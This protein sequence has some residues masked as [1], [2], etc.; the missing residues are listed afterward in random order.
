MKWLLI[1]LMMEKFYIPLFSLVVQ[2]K[3]EITKGP[4]EEWII[5]LKKE[6]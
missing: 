2:S 5:P 3:K 1:A 6:M 4:F